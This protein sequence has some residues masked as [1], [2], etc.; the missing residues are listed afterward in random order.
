MYCCSPQ[1]RA[2]CL[3]TP[4]NF[5]REILKELKKDY[6]TAPDEDDLFGKSIGA[7]LKMIPQQKAL[8]KMKIEQLMYKIQYCNVQPTPYFPC[9]CIDNIYK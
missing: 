3:P 8:A 9:L 1:K 6:L 5:K 4:D 7:S 2:R